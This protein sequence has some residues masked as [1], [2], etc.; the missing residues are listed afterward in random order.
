MSGTTLTFSALDG[1]AFAA[2]RGRL[3]AVAPDTKFEAGPLGPLM[4]L[5]Q[6]GVEGL[7]PHP[8]KAAWLDLGAAVSFEAALRA[9]SKQW[10]GGDR[11]STG[12]FR[13]GVT[14]SE[15]DTAWVGFGLAAQKAAV[16]GGFH[17]RI[18]A[19]FAAAL[20]E[21]V[22]NI[23]EHAG[24][25]AS[26][27]AAFSAGIG[28]FEFVVADHGV[29]ILE[30]LRSGPDYKSL[31]DHGHALRLALTDGVSRY[32]RQAKRGNGFRPIFVGLAN[33]SGMLRFRTGD[34]ALIIDG[35]KIDIVSAKTAQKA[36]MKGF[37]VSVACR[38]G[39]KEL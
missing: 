10:I 19:Q 35:Q 9:G 29:G 18:A 7:L 13:I 12:F 22:S 3:N 11:G 31:A 2:D 5:R 34:H 14:W 17:R 33:L 23:H 1:L 6:L 37:L 30:S 15:D 39:A 36:P 16:A 32:G 38:R 20:V 8:D 21:M 4:E 24:A 26:G 28:E 27:I 25:S